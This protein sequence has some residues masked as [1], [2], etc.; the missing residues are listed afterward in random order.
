MNLLH[1]IILG[2]VE[3][4]TEFLP[5]SSTAHLVLTANILKVAQS[6]F[7]K[8]FEIM[9]QF[10]AIL[11][12]IVLY[13]KQFLLDLESLKRIIVAFIP[14]AILGFLL[15]K[16]IK[17]YLISSEIIIIWALLIGGIVLIAFELF[18][19]EK[20]TAHD[21]ISTIP[22]SK[23]LAIGLFQS[24]AMFPG[25]SRSAA[26]IIGGLAINLKRQTI[27]EFSFLLA[28]PTMLAASVLDIV[29]SGSSFTMDQFGILAIGFIISFIVA[30]LSIN[31][32]MNFIKKHTFIPFGIYR[33]IIALIFMASI[34]LVK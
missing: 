19:K 8:S 7:V 23:C 22:Y 15:Y 26:T 14:T 3:G 29:K 13:W 30:L 11:S 12:V 32:L 5:I 20:D 4:I 21:D 34:Y 10:G 24:L 17:K 1:S 2:V 16:I 33:I 9:I 31:F 27:V 18:H 25:V 28:V 6:E